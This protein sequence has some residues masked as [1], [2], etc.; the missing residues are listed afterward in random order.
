MKRCLE[1][2]LVVSLT[3]G[4]A[5]A[6]PVDEIDVDALA[7]LVQSACPAHWESL[8]S[9]FAPAAMQGDPWRGDG[10]DRAAF[11]AY[12]QQVAIDNAANASDVAGMADDM[13]TV[14]TE[15]GAQ[16]LRLL[17]VLRAKLPQGIAASLVAGSQTGLTQSPDGLSR[18]TAGLSCNAIKVGHPNSVNNLYWID[19]NTGDTADAFQVYCDMTSEGGGWTLV[20]A[21][22]END[23][24]SDWNEGIQADYDPSL[25]TQ[26]GFALSTDQ[27]PAHAETAFGKDLAATHVDYVDFVYGTGNIPKTVVAGKR[28]DL[29]RTYHVHRST[30]GY[31]SSHDPDVAATSGASQWSNTLT[32]DQTPDSG[33]NWAFSP[34]ATGAENTGYAMNGTPS[35][36][37]ANAY[38]WT[39]WVR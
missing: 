30:D 1:C 10:A 14:I 15:C 29:N 7:A 12:L 11:V 16:R 21:Q 8:T 2:L 36:G 31:F 26:T 34:L 13:M 35:Q 38:A 24:V 32:L 25:A 9:E 6:Q 37:I 22:Y 33:F 19:V 3:V 5:A 23:P 17:G 20:A 18:Q 4:N 27:L 28:Q 39:V